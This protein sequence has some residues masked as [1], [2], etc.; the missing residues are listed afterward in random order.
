MK[1]IV[2]ILS[3][4]SSIIVLGGNSEELIRVN[5][6]LNQTYKK[7]WKEED[8]KLSLMIQEVQLHG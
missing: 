2:F 6:A 1:I 5:N 8:E 7:K 3:M 4:F